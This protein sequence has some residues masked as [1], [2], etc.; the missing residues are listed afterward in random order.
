MA[1]YY[2][3]FSFTKQ[4]IALA[5]NNASAWNYLRGVLDHNRVP[6][7]TQEAFVV[8]Y[9]VAHPPEVAPTGGGEN[10]VDLENPR[11]SRESQL[12]CSLAIEF[13]ADIRESQGKQC[14][15]IE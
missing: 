8:P 14:K 13:L 11:P 3:L 2:L 6:Y 12:P 10:V 4:K 1:N 15:A 9:A 5:P 7:S